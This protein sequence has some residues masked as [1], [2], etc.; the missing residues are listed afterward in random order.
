MPHTRRR[1]VPSINV[2][3]SEP[4]PSSSS[5]HSRR[6][7]HGSLSSSSLFSRSN[8]TTSSSS[9]E[10]I[11]SRA[12]L[13]R[14]RTVPRVPLRLRPLDAEF[15]P[16]RTERSRSWS[17]RRH[18]EPQSMLSLPEWPD[19]FPGESSLQETD[20]G[21]LASGTLSFADDTPSVDSR[22]R[23]LFGDDRHQMPP[24][25]AISARRHAFA[26]R[27]QQLALD[28][29]PTPPPEPRIGFPDTPTPPPPPTTPREPPTPLPSPLEPVPFYAARVKSYS[30][31][32]AHDTNI[33][34]LWYRHEIIDLLPGE[35]TPM[36]VRALQQIDNHF[37]LRDGLAEV[38]NDS[39]NCENFDRRHSMPHSPTNCSDVASRDPIVK[40][41]SADNPHPFVVPP[42]AR[43]HAAPTRSTSPMSVDDDDDNH[44]HAASSTTDPYPSSLSCGHL[45]TG[46]LPSSGSA[47][48]PFSSDDISPVAADDVFMH[49]LATPST[50]D[51]S[52]DTQF[53]A[54]NTFASGIARSIIASAGIASAVTPY[55]SAIAAALAHSTFAVASLASPQDMELS[56]STS[57]CT[58][59]TVVSSGN[60]KSSGEMDGAP[61]LI[62]EEMEEQMEEDEAK[63]RDGDFNL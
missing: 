41:A 55:P 35:A 30:F 49:P 26:A 63:D 54:A 36:E 14:L 15:E 24:P 33:V 61:A 6:P 43:Y 39:P 25:T 46:G 19:E 21:S 2:S 1:M 13:N 22:D 4:E 58:M 38:V 48:T 60:R 42:P 50:A 10:V 23:T 20:I 8:S 12:E 53:V 7:S 45:S 37:A 56:S 5:D 47:N 17:P 57:D 40:S 29:T 3:S 62:P 28:E 18:R 31:C 11:F 9:N 16:S 32:G 44:H 34:N 51:T 59:V 27:R 52:P